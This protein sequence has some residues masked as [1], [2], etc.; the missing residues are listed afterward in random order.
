LA[1]GIACEDDRAALDEQAGELDGFLQ[2]APG[3]GAQVNDDAGNLFRLQ[4]GD[5][6][7]DVLGTIRISRTAR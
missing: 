1:V 7:G 4:L 2:R 6:L 3:I 5:Q